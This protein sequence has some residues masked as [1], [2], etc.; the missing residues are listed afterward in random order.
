M[1]IP[2]TRAALTDLVRTSYEKLGKELD[3]VD[4]DDADLPCVDDWSTK[5]MLAVRVWW[6]E[7]VVE[8]IQMGQRGEH[9]A[10]PAPGYGWRETPR[11]NANIVAQS[12]TETFE[13]IRARL[14]RGA[15]RVL[16]TIDALDDRELLEPAVFDWAGK[17]PIARWIS[18]NTAR[19]YATAR[20]Y[21]RRALRQRGGTT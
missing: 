7:H 14:D 12:K 20:T 4:P 11:L 6:T 10:T 17:W 2:R 8:W 18:I 21:V 19:Q 3:A 5:D 13:S 16:A 1:P 9:P 15:A